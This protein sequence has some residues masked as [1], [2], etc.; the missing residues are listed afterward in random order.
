MGI[1]RTLRN[2][3]VRT[4][5]ADSRLVGA[6][7]RTVNSIRFRR[8]WDEP[9]SFRGAQLVIGK[10]LSLYPFVR[11]GGF[12]ER[13]LDWILAR[14]PRDAVAWDVGANIGLYTV[15]LARAAADGHVVAFEPMPS[16]L[17]RLRAKLAR[18]NVRNVTIE[19]VALSNTDGIATMRVLPHAAGGNSLDD[20][21][22]ST[23]P[24]VPIITADEFYASSGTAPHVVKVDIEGHEPQFVAGAREV[25]SQ[26]RPTLLLEVN[27]T[28]FL[29]DAAKRA[30]WEEMVAFLFEVYDNASWFSPTSVEAVRGLS[31]QDVSDRPCTLAFQAQ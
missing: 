23:G 4:P 3:I 24:R 22:T 25:I 12:E 5:L 8:K 11:A 2:V 31:P 6:G 30:R 7:Y 1:E 16:T 14:T 26:G 29:H 17:A 9:V 19:P 13:E 28:R 18:N 15:L 27:G 10:D 20:T 21:G